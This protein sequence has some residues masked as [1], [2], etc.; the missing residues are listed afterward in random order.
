[1]IAMHIFRN[2]EDMGREFA[3]GSRIIEAN[4]HIAVGLLK[5]GMQ[6]GKSSVSLML[7]LPDG[8]VVFAETSLA[9]FLQAAS[10]FKII[11]EGA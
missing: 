4:K 1:M 6:S 9:L 2:A 10:M 3:A 11:D 7:E 8:S 5:R